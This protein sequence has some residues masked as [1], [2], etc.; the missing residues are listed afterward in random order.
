MG[1]GADFPNDDVKWWPFAYYEIP[2][3]PGEDDSHEYPGLSNARTGFALAGE[4][5]ELQEGERD[6][7]ISL[8][9]KQSLSKK[10]FVRGFKVES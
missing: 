9:F 1:K 5:F 4:I 3:S 10:I 6:V 7:V 8:D 2:P